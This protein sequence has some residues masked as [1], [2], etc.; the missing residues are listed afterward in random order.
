MFV[1][2]F[3]S[4]THTCFYCSDV[5]FFQVGVQP[6]YVLSYVR[7]IP[8]QRVLFKDSVLSLVLHLL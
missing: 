5:L 8:H 1:L 7:H 3:F 2:S 4:F 6:S